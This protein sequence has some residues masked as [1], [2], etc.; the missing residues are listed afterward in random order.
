MNWWLLTYTPE[1]VEIW[2][3]DYKITEFYSYKTNTPPHI[4]FIGLS[5]TSD[6]SY[7][8]LDKI[9]DEM[10]RR[11][12][13]IAQADYDY[14][15]GGGKS[16]ITSF[17]D[18]RK[19]YGKNSM[20]RLLIIVDEFHVMSQHAQLETE[21]KTKLENIL[22]EARALGIILLL[23]DQAIVDGLRGLSDKG[24]KQI[25]ARIAL[26][27][28]KD[29]LEETLNEKEADK[30]RSFIHMKV[31]E[32]AVQTIQ[33]NEDR[34]EVPTIERAMAIYING[35][36]RYNV[37][38]KARTIYHAEDYVADVFDDRVVDPMKIEEIDQW[39]KEN[40]ISHR[41]GSKDIHIYLGRPVNLGF[42]L[43][44]PLLQRKGNNIMCASGTEEQQ[45]RI[46]RAII[47]SFARQSDFSV[48]IMA[49]SYASVYRE[50]KPEILE[51]EKN[52]PEIRVHDDLEDICYKIVETLEIIKDRSNTRKQLIV[53]L[54]LDSMADILAD[55]RNKRTPVLKK[56]E[57]KATQS[58]V[59]ESVS[60]EESEKTDFNDSALD[61][62]S[63]LFG[64]MDLFGEEDINEEEP[65]TG[66]EA[67]TSYLY[68]ARNDIA[69]IIHLG[70]TCNVF[71]LVIY[72]SASALRDFREVKTLDFNHKIA[73]PMSDYEAGEFLDQPRL[74]RELSG[75]LAYYHNGRAGNRFVPYKL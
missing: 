71:N 73:F 30:I 33:E 26:S 25:K 22:S 74:I 18:Y 12:T 50:Y 37:N 24:K 70:P 21:Y 42:A 6:F 72:D 40:V 47:S 20:T 52:Y 4:R 51:F 28:Y 75:Q 15:A 62:F 29:E 68:D 39:E 32:V 1:D 65:E 5:K 55:E 11:Q 19:V 13:I 58:E 59:S 45:M 69:R 3:S 38:E 53:W 44:F 56:A 16:N 49:D 43:H 60:E 61:E 27:N 48:D 23:S 66:K 63:A 41:D 9:I 2:L 64:D 67:Q 7:A 57:E 34:E 17:G 8:F 10:N 31:G 36:C 14:K 46:L 35:T 54:G